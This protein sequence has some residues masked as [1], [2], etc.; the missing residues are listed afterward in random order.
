MENKQRKKAVFNWSGGKDSA[1]ALYQMMKENEYDIVALLTTVNN[2]NDRSSMHA[3]PVSLLRKQ[4]DSIG[5]PLYIAGLEPQGDMRDYENAMKQAVEHFVAQGVTHFIFGDIFLQDVKA[6]REKQLH[7]YGITVVEPLWGKTSEE[8]MGEFVASGLRTIIVTTMVDSLGEEFIGKEIDAIFETCLPADVDVC[9]E[10][11]EY[12]T[13]CYAG[14][15][16]R[17]P[18]RY[19]LGKPLHIVHP[20]RMEDGTEKKFTYW[21]ADLLDPEM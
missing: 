8:V 18:V 13:F 3:I 17:W 19:L 11:G 20:V 12:H 14:G 4:A 5:I 6:Y 1:L 2:G 15:M 10:N 16:F 21:F 7:P 9:G